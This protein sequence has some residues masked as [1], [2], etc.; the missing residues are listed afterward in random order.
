MTLSSPFHEEFDAFL[1]GMIFS[2]PR[3]LALFA[4]MPIFSKEALP[5]LIR[6]CVAISVAVVVA[7][8]LAGGA[9]AASKLGLPYLIAVAGKECLIG[10]MLGFAV[11]VP[12]WAFEGIGFL[13]DMQ[14]GASIASVLDPVTG[15]DTS[16]L[17]VLFG[18]AMIVFF[19]VSGAYLQMLGLLY[20]SFRLWPVYDWWPTMGAMAPG[21]FLGMLDHLMRLTLLL[22]A[23]LV[24]AMLLVEIGMA[25]V[26]RSAPQMDVF[27][28]A[29]PVKSA[30]VFLMLVLYCAVLFDYA[31]KELAR[32]TDVLFSLGTAL[33]QQ[34][35]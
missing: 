24:I 13:V 6:I 20:E 18:Q 25:I 33:P 30:V 14:R 31:G 27:F 34:T 21:L 16:P 19:F 35:R 7:P 8:A 10:L 17:G 22:S 11:A 28:L 29:M 23:P 12:L 3:I 15:H 26:G 2:L 1:T 5:H 32:L 9:D 4:L